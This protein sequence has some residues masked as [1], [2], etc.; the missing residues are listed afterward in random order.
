MNK[1]DY[2]GGSIVNLVSS[3][4]QGLGGTSDYPALRQ[5]SGTALQAPRHVALL[6]ID[7]L[8]ADWLAARSPN[9]LLMRALHARLTTVFPSTTAAA[10]PTFLTGDAPLQHG[11][12][13]WHTYIGELACVMTVLPGRPRFGGVT[14][15]RAGVDPLSII[16]GTPLF[17]RIR[18]KGVQIATPDIVGSDFNQALQGVAKALPCEGLQDLF[19]QAARVLKPWGRN[20]RERSYLYLYWSKLDAIGH[21]F[22]MES[23]AAEAHLRELE[24]AIEQFLET[25]AGTDTLLLVSADHGQ[26]DSMREDEINLEHYPS[27]AQHLSLPLCGE[28]RAAFCYLRSG[29]EAEFLQ[30]CREDFGKRVEVVSTALLTEQGFFGTGRPHPRFWERV[31]DYC[32]LPTGQGVIRQR[33]MFERSLQHIGAHGGLTDAEL[34]VPLSLFHV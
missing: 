22:G 16:G 20:N 11:L 33:L 15:R 14:Y 12:T 27:V 19:R 18:A 8:G 6:V 3:L 10:I 28:P 30:A 32:L 31:G 29:H 25:I 4:I 2:A 17:N 26:I 13:G 5:L 1:P 34:M 21:E 9:G 7:G 24:L 23:A